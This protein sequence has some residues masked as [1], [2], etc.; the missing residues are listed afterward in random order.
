ML[1]AVAYRGFCMPIDNHHKAHYGI[2]AALA[3]GC[4]TLAL[5]AG[6]IES[7]FSAMKGQVRHV[8]A[9][10]WPELSEKQIGDLA[11]EIKKLRERGVTIYCT[12]GCGTLPDDLMTAFRAAGWADAHVENALG[13]ASGLSVSPDNDEGRAIAAAITTAT[14]IKPRMIT[15]EGVPV[16][17]VVGRK[18]KS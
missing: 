1:E 8:V 7:S 4:V 6:H 14:G 11:A 3:I 10:E 15:Q 12:S 16:A 13:I 2:A 9:Q 18:G 17:I 5:N